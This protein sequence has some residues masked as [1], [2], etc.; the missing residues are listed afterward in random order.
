MVRSAGGSVR[1]CALL[2]RGG[3]RHWFNVVL[4]LIEF[5]CPKWGF[6][7]EW[8]VWRVE[9]KVVVNVIVWEVVVDVGVDLHVVSLS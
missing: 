3:T 5:A 8:I 2:L 6:V 7:V 9:V 4:P 1:A